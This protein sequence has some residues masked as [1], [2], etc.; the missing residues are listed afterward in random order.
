MY[1]RLVDQ[2]NLQVFSWVGSKIWNVMPLNVS[3]TKKN[4]FKP[5][6]IH[7]LNSLDT[8]YFL[9]PLSRLFMHWRNYFNL[10]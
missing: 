5:N 8:F 2:S 7:F 10:S 4:R 3:K 9:F 1:G 6:G